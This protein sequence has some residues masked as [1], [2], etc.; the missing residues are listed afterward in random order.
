MGLRDT[1]TQTHRRKGRESTAHQSRGE[2][3]GG[4][5]DGG[6]SRGQTLGVLG[7][8]GPCPW[9]GSEKALCT[10]A[11]S[12]TLGAT[13][14]VCAL[15]CQLCRLWSGAAPLSLRTPGPAGAPA[16]DELGGQ[17]SAEAA[18]PFCALLHSVRGRAAAAAGEIWVFREKGREMLWSPSGYP[19]QRRACSRAGRKLVVTLCSCLTQTQLPS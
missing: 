8:L 17:S 13:P 4:S 14:A 15:K 3:W 6:Q 2:G 5:G 1:H 12:G 11:P 19:Q 9:K 16:A 18:V 10:A 7:T